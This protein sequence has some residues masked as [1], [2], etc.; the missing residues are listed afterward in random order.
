MITIP[1]AHTDNIHQQATN[2]PGNDNF[3]AL[4]TLC[5]QIGLA[6]ICFQSLA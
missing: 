6:I 5:F 2:C 4:A 1:R 3:A